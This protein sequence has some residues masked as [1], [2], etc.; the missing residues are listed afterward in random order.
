MNV[1]T[2]PIL[3]LEWKEVGVRVL[4]VHAGL[5][6]MLLCR[7]LPVRV[8]EKKVLRPAQ[9]SLHRL[10]VAPDGPGAEKAQNWT[11][12]APRFGSQGFML[13]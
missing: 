11:L 8:R 13:A 12:S 3:F 9:S 10:R 1:F 2:S 7:S 6:T 5:A 4:R